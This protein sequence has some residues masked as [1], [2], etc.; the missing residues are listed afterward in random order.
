LA[1]AA[2]ESNLD[3]VRRALT[4]FNSEAEDVPIELFSEDFESEVPAS[5]SAEPDVYRGREGVRRWIAGFE[6]FM[7]EVRIEAHEVVEV[8]PGT[9]LASMNLVARGIESGIEVGQE[10]FLVVRVRDGQLQRIDPFPTREEAL[11]AAESGRP[12]PG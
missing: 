1:A 5:M 9:V 7:D 2:V 10:G 4:A 8:R 3:V 11:A 12:E 6:G